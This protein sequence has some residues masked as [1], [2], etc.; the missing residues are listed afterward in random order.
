MHSEYESLELLGQYCEFHFGS[1]YFDVP[2]FPFAC[3]EAALAAI[4]ERVP[5]RVLDIGCAVGRSSFEL[6]RQCPDVLGVD[7]SQRFVDAAY[8]LLETG[9][10]EWE[11]VR[12]GELR[13]G[14][15][16]SLADLNWSPAGTL[17][18]DQGDACAMDGMWR[19]FDMICAFNLLCR[20]PSPRQF[21]EGAAARLNPGGVLVLTTPGT[22]MEAFTP[23]KEW[24]GGFYTEAGMPVTTFDGINT[25]L[26]GPFSLIDGPREIPFVIRETRRKYQHSTAQFTAWQLR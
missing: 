11:I 25:V 18:F 14:K 21:L 4:G 1:D 2:N 23:R 9:S 15:Q 26:D 3:V 10:L 6:A 19:G 7:R 17:R 20:L 12:E 5:Q 16:I 24:L 22:W 8:G 13:V